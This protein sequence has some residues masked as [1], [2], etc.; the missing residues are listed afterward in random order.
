MSEGKPLALAGL[1]GAGKTSVGRWLA[2]LT[3]TRFDDLDRLVEVREGRTICE[4]FGEGEQRFRRAERA[5]LRAWLAS[6]AA[7][8]G[9]VLALG[10]GTL[11]H[12]A[13]A[14]ALVSGCEIVHL[15][16]S[17]FALEKR[18]GEAEI[19]ARPLLADSDDP[20]ATLERLAGERAP[21]YA[22]AHHRFG[23]ETSEPL[24]V[25][26]A[27]L[28][29][30]YG[31]EGSRHRPP[32]VLS[33][34]GSASGHVTAGRGSAPFGDA[35][36]KILMLDAGMPRVQRDAAR[37]LL[38][39]CVHLEIPGGET[40]KSPAQ[41]S[42]L[43]ERLLEESV[44]RDTALLA[45]GGGTLTDLAGLLAHTFKRG[46]VLDLLPTTLLGQLDAALGGKNGI[47]VGKIKNAVGTIR[48]P[49]QVHLDPLFFP[50]LSDVDLRGGLAEAVKSALIGD[51]GLFEFIEGE[52][53]A[54]AR[55]ALDPLEEVAYRSAAVK[56]G[57]VAR[58]LEESGDRRQLNLGHTL[59]HAL[60]SLAATRG[61]DL[62]HGDAVA[63]G[64]VFACHLAARVGVLEDHRLGKRVKS[65]LSD[66]S[67]PISAE[68][69]ASAAD[70]GLLISAIG[71][72]KKRAAGENLWIL[73]RRAG[74]L[75]V[76]TLARE[77]VATALG[78]FLG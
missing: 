45:V 15:E 73:P 62:S 23:T 35:P 55:R 57:I 72:D 12:E 27:I 77:D 10:G 42:E 47:N 33:D 43:W 58:D 59:G 7:R 40:C 32:R 69:I 6:D 46:I 25:A 74:D 50:T 36:R 68:G 21:G 65:L 54:L 17:P 44:D 75:E 28:R 56:L 8:E 38:P 37:A 11:Q 78:E 29:K 53:A 63:I 13:S 71:R 18:L 3:G 51:E 19:A 48:L 31:P 67:L 20:R 4:L 76:T 5:A 30:L 49:R 26:V 39:K 52:T 1:M 66:L 2:Q 14:N 70:R 9:G 22:R 34:P 60:E 64:M 16:A 61:L 41:L 24:H